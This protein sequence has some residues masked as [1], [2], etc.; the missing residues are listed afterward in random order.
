[1]FGPEEVW[2]QLP[3]HVRTEIVAK[4]AK[5]Y[6]I[7]ANA[8]A[9]AANM[10]GRINTIMQVC[11]FAISGVLPREEALNAIRRSIRQTYGKKGDEIVQMNLKAVEQALAHLHEVRIPA[12]VGGNGEGGLRPPV[13]EKAPPFVRQ[14]LGPIIAGCGDCLPVSQLPVD[15]TFPTGT[16]Q[17][18]K[19]NIATETPVW[20]PAT[21]TQC[22]KCALVCPH[23]V[24]RIKA[25]DSKCLEGAPPSFKS[26]EAKD[27]DWQ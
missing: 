2:G 1:A 27:R 12:D 7:D 11:F 5:L 21:C 17:W 18:E 6:V 4:R 24:I 15:G 9:R 3:A 10:G 16:S 19:R 22:G 13:P 25:Y 20:D 26:C 23:G 8:V 14:V